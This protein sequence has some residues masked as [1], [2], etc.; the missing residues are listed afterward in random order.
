MTRTHRWTRQSPP[1][2]PAAD[3]VC[4]MSERQRWPAHSIRSNAGNNPGLSTRELSTAQDN[5]RPI[6]G[7]ALHASTDTPR[8]AAGFFEVTGLPEQK[9]RHERKDQRDAQQ[10]EGIAEG[11]D[12]GLFL[13]DVA[14]RDQR[15]VRRVGRI[16]DAVV[17]E[18]LRER[19]DPRAPFLS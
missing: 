5:D 11:Q 15:A 13:H 3:A 7:L 2:P 16:E 18:I 19:L 1:S 9:G 17:D 14:D 4:S 10:I 8:R 6:A 12:E